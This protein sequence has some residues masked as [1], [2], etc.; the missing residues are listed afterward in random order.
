MA[1]VA[2]GAAT[3]RQVGYWRDN[4]T[5]YRHTLEVTDGNYTIRNNY[6]NALVERGDL[7]A[8]DQGVPRGAED[9]AAFDQGSQ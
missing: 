6:A 8:A 4:I 3:W 7:D 1:V 5:L 9:L 2:S